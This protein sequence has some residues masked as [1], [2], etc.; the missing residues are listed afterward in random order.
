MTD[1]VS[2]TARFYTER[3][4]FRPSFESDWYVSLRNDEGPRPFELG[5]L[6]FDHETVPEGFRERSRGIL[7]NLEVDDAKAEFDRL[8]A[9]PGLR[10]ALDLRDE[11][12]GQ[13]HF[14]IVDPADNLVD[15]IENIP[16]SEAFQAQFLED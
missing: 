14:I 16:P 7:I 2:E 9:S 10:V 5:V 6:R 4:G 12:F 3:F 15:V 11:E 13:R 1:K 8:T